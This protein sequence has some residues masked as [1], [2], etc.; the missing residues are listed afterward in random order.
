MEYL[1]YAYKPGAE[2]EE[3]K[4]ALDESLKYFKE[5]ADSIS[6]DKM[7]A[8]CEEYRRQRYYEGVIEF[9]LERA[10]KLDPHEKGLLYMESKMRP[11]DSRV[12]SYDL[13]LRCYDHI[14]VTLTEIKNLQSGKSYNNI[15]GRND[16]SNCDG[17]MDPNTLFD[18]ILQ[19]AL[20]HDD[21]LFH[22]TLY[23][24]FLQ[25]DRSRELLWV[26]SKHII[27]FFKQ[28]V[29]ELDSIQF[30]WQYYRRH[31]QYY[32]AA[33]YL[34][35]LANRSPNITADKRLE[36]IG[37]ALWYAQS[38]EASDKPTQK[39]RQ[40]IIRL[41]SQMDSIMGQSVTEQ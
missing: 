23:Q 22:Y 39:T 21:K 17:D 26:D 29:S 40:L 10:R 12:Q 1:H 9:A 31:Q 5:V 34:E 27:P 6:E 35:A 4:V 33:L 13:R 37:L 15:N 24:W 28:H 3:T 2:Y 16:N 38:Q 32:E 14:F 8:I 25:N 19:R 11:G 18:T 41:Q 7:T 20:S 30:L 36:Y